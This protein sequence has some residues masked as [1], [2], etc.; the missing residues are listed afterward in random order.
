MPRIR[1]W[2]CRASFSASPRTAYSGIGSGQKCFERGCLRLVGHPRIVRTELSAR[3][4]PTS[5]PDRGRRSAGGTGPNGGSVSP[6]TPGK[7]KASRIREDLR[8]GPGRRTGRCP[9]EGQPA[10]PLFATDCRPRPDLLRRNGT[11]TFRNRT[12]RCRDRSAIAPKRGKRPAPAQSGCRRFRT[13]RHRGKE[14]G[15]QRSPYSATS[16]AASSGIPTA[17]RARMWVSGLRIIVVSGD[18]GSTR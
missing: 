15:D 3:S 9:G 7:T 13:T 5:P 4:R 17:A 1:E 18:P 10:T 14:T 6:K 8:S 2:E 11:R 12:E 16:R